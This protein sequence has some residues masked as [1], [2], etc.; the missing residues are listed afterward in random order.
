[1]NDHREVVFAAWMANIGRF[2]EGGAIRLIEKC[3]KILDKYMDTAILTGILQGDERYKLAKRT[4]EAAFN[5]SL[6]ESERKQK[7]AKGK[8]LTTVFARV[9]A[10]E[11][12]YTEKQYYSI[13]EEAAENF[14]PSFSTDDSK[15]RELSKKFERELQMLEKS[16]ADSWAD[17]IVVFDSLCRKYMWCITASDYEGE[18]ISLYNQSRIAGAI[19][20]C[21]CECDAEHLEKNTDE[22]LWYKLVVCDFSGIQKYVFSVASVN[23]KGVAKRLRARSFYID[24]TV[25]V[26]AQAIISELKLTQ[27][28]ILMQT[29]GKFYLLLPNTERTEQIL[30]KMEKEISSKFFEMFGGQVAI[31]L[32]WLTINAHGLENYSVSVKELLRL[33]NQKKNSAFYDVLTNDGKWIQEKFIIRND[34][35][36]KKICSSCGN[37]L[38]SK[39]EQMCKNCLEQTEIGGRIPK[40]KYIA[41]YTK[42]TRPKEKTYHIYGRY[43]IG[44]MEKYKRDKAFLVEQIN[45]SVRPQNS[46]GAPVRTRFMANHIPVNEAQENLSFSD[47]AGKARGTQKLAVLKADVD[48]LGYIFADGLRQGERHFGTIS[49]VNTMSR[50]LE[51]FFSGYINQ[52]ISQGK[53]YQNVYSVFSGGDDLFLIGPWDIMP[54]LA[55]DIQKEFQ[56]FAAQNQALTLSATVSVFHPKEHIANQA[57]ISEKR[58]KWVKNNTVEE[59][60][61]KKT[62]RNG[63][64]FFGTLYSWEDLDAQLAIG[65]RLIKLVEQKKINVAM[66]RRIEKYSRMYK[67]FLIDKDV[68]KLIFEPLAAYDRNRNYGTLKKADKEVEWFLEDYTKELTRNAADTRKVKKNLYFA[69]ETIRYVLYCLKEKRNNG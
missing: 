29:G 16:P 2:Y 18:D 6:C 53:E 19:A 14:F 23:E 54:R 20:K 60:Y 63:V 61:P 58:L 17:F 27:N 13:A 49:R 40:T 9:T 68:M 4:V 30:K 66:L 48:N 65:E 47:I 31:H 8:N 41:Y 38:I 7:L 42:E 1:M 3:K 59:L 28:H 51:G 44:L 56:R 37:A 26:I 57:E 25:S 33:L 69:E 46:I 22:P 24:V 5:L 15:V 64:S 35:E 55:C 10:E 67:E 32:A 50:F 62:G 39:E 45:D 34:L 12:E 52:M 21:M 43:Y 11:G 36:N